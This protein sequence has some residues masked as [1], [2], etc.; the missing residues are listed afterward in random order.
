MLI[1]ILAIKDTSAVATLISR[2]KSAAT[3]IATSIVVGSTERLTLA[4][5]VAVALTSTTATG[6]HWLSRGAATTGLLS[7]DTVTSI[8]TTVGSLRRP[9]YDDASATL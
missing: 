5:I 8:A 4:T 7:T 2:F 6:S 3:T 1:I 9:C